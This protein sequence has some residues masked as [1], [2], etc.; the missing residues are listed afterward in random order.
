[1][2]RRRAAA[3]MESLEELARKVA[4]LERELKIQR[5]ALDKLKQLGI[6]NVPERAPTKKSA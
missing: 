6:K 3:G 1:M 5:L 2:A 4:I